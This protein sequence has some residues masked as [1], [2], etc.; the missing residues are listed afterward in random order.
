[1]LFLPYFYFRFGQKWLSVPRW[2]IVARNARIT[3]HSRQQTGTE[4]YG[5]SA[6][7]QNTTSGSTG[8]EYLTTQVTGRTFLPFR[9]QRL[10]DC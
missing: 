2:P 10:S 4:C 1:M 6:D 3:L 7:N 8:N 5:T 9:L